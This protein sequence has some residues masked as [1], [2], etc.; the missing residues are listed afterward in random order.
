MHSTTVWI[1]Q[2][3]PQVLPS[4]SLEL[5][6]LG[7]SSRR[8]RTSWHRVQKEMTINQL[9]LD[10]MVHKDRSLVFCQTTIR[11]TWQSILTVQKRVRL[12]EKVALS[13]T[14]TSKHTSA[15]LDV[16][17]TANLR[18]LPPWDRLTYMRCK[19]QSVKDVI[20]CL[21][22]LHRTQRGSKKNPL[23]QDYCDIFSWLNT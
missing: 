11:R 15:Q 19:K 7:S 9:Q 5:S 17:S 1:A 6:L 2:W 10:H 12:V 18:T 23:N 16:K 8:L 21:S 13:S 22:F 20:T 3:P 4:W 14:M